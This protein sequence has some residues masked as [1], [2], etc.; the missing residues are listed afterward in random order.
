MSKTIT[1]IRELAGLH[2]EMYDYNYKW[3]GSSEQSLEKDID[4]VVESYGYKFC[5]EDIGIIGEY[6][7]I[8]AYYN[9]NIVEIGM[10]D[11]LMDQEYCA[12]CDNIALYKI[13]E[14]ETPLCYNC[15]SIYRAGQSSPG[16]SIME[17]DSRR[18]NARRVC[19]TCGSRDTP[20]G[21]VG[22]LCK[23]GHDNW[24]EYRDI[25]GHHPDAE[26]IVRNAM[27]IFSLTLMELE[28]KFMGDESFE[29]LISKKRGGGECGK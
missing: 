27:K 19:M 3:R 13:V 23:N 11:S 21:Y 15:M 29:D 28:T 1:T 17:L 20:G 24:L 7:D 6:N 16:S 18:S 9:C 22:G 14:T 12:F 2:P 25:M 26:D 4:K 5:E 8:K 10:R